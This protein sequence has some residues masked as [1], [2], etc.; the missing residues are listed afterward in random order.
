[1]EM[2]IPPAAVVAVFAAAMWLI[3]PIFP[4]FGFPLPVRQLLSLIVA[5]MGVAVV[6]AGIASFRKTHTTINPMRPESASALVESGLYSFTR[7]PMYLGFLLILAGWAVF[8]ANAL[9]ALL[10]AGFVLYMNRFQIIPEE[11]ALLERFGDAFSAYSERVR[12]WL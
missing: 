3:A 6:V 2:K 4:A 7:N 11:R 9:S 5:V 12:R 1:M 10:L 8:L